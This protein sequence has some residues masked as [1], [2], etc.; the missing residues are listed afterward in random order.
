MKDSRPSNFQPPQSELEQSAEYVEFDFFSMQRIGR[1]RYLAYST[2]V[3]IIG[4][5]IIMLLV[6][7]AGSNSPSGHNNPVDMIVFIVLMSMG[8]VNLILTVRRFHDFNISGLFILLIVVPFIN[9]FLSLAL[10]LVS[11]TA[12]P[13]RF[14]L[15]S[16]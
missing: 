12:G 5:G 8:V 11:G 10:L 6:M 7:I 1:L 4:F 9:I 2:I 3:T 16:R 15:P 14:G 13:N